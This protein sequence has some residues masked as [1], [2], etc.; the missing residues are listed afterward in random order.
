MISQGDLTREIEAIYEAAGVYER[1]EKVSLRKRSNKEY[2]LTM[3][4]MYG[5]VAGGLKVMVGLGKLFG[6]DMIDHHGQWSSN[7]CPTC[8]YGSQYVIEYKITLP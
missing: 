7:G 2:I 8:D 1:P 5:H 3:E 4:R 6:T